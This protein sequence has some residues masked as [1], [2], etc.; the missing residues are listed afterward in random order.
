MK[1]S[2]GC[3]HAHADVGDDV[4]GAGDVEGDQVAAVP[5]AMG[6]EEG[7]HLARPCRMRFGEGRSLERG[8]HMGHAVLHGDGVAGR[9][10][11]RA[12]AGAVVFGEESG[13]GRLVA[14]A[15]RDGGERVPGIVAGV[16]T[17][18]RAAVL[19]GQEGGA[20]GMLG[21]PGDNGPERPAEIQRAGRLARAFSVAG[22][23]QRRQQDGVLVLRAG[24]DRVQRQ[25]GVSGVPALL[26][27]GQHRR[28]DRVLDATPGDGAQGIG[29]RVLPTPAAVA[30]GDAGQAGRQDAKRR[31]STRALDPA[32]CGDGRSRGAQVSPR[33]A[34]VE[35]GEAGRQ[36]GTVA[37]SG[38]DGRV[39]G[40][41]GAVA[42]GRTLE[43][44]EAGRHDRLLA[45]ARGG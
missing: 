24:A 29:Q 27:V 23:D 28:H 39:R 41:E 37:P 16:G 21:A 25:S 7:G 9:I 20:G 44:Q 14:A 43:G 45:A 30:M 32:V 18:A 1:S 36:Q 10:G 8:L 2:R 13:D 12:V 34:G 4:A 42:A 35:A 26:G 38:Q 5:G 40:V 3:E 22:L 19:L 33:G 15:G 11:A 17:H 6:A 31:G